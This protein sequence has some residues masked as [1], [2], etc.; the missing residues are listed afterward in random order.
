MLWNFDISQPL[1]V[2]GQGVTARE[3][4]RVLANH[5]V[6][7]IT[8]LSIEQLDSVADGSQCIIAIRNIA[9]R[10]SIIDQHEHRFS[11][12]SFAH[13]HSDITDIQCLGKGVWVDSFS[14]IGSEVSLGDF[15]IVTSQCCVSHNCRVGRNSFLA[16]GTMIMGSTTI[17]DNVYFGTRCTVLDHLTITSGSILSAGSL[18]HKDIIEPGKYVHNRKVS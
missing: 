13:V 5:G 15:S 8:S 7:N 10:Q 16:P 18:V 1:Y 11:W 9:A 14:A 3:F 12:P 2:V 6:H 4:V 17:G